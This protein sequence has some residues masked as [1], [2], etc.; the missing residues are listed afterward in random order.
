MWVGGHRHALAA[1]PP[2][3]TRYPM[4][5]KLEGPQR[6]S[7]LVRK[8]SPPPGFNPRTVQPVALKRITDR[9]MRRGITFGS[10]PASVLLGSKL[11]R[12]GVFSAQTACARNIPRADV[13]QEA[14][15]LVGVIYKTSH[16]LGSRNKLVHVCNKGG[17]GYRGTGN[18]V[19]FTT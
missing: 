2:G 9:F 18:A 5:R 12:T 6:R 13:I 16:V 17:G 4:Y 1:L 7:G 14:E 8:I 19:K 3:K 15:V 10:D 11:L